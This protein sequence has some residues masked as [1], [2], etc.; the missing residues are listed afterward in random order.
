MDALTE[1]PDSSRPVDPTALAEASS[2]LSERA[3]IIEIACDLG[4]LHGDYADDTRELAETAHE[5]T[6]LVD[7]FLTHGLQ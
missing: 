7:Q 2:R 1:L 3:G 5:L 6:A 4:E